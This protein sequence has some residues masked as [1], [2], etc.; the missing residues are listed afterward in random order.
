[1]H[2]DFIKKLPLPSLKNLQ[3]FVEV[4]SA[5]SINTAA[6]HLNITPSAVSHQIAALE[7]FLG[8]KLFIRNGKG[9]TLTQ[10]G[11]E[12]LHQISG[13]LN[14]IGRVSDKMINEPHS[15][16][17]RVHSAPS[18]GI[19]WLIRKLG[20]FRKRHPEILINL[21]C[22][23]ENLQFSRD[24][25]DIDIRH[26]IA[27]WDGYRVLTIKNERLQV[28]AS[29][30]Y[31]AEHPLSGPEEIINHNLIH[32]SSTLANWERWFSYHKI[33]TNRH[34]YNLSFD[35]SYMSFEAAKMGLGIILE[36]S[37]LG[38]E[39]I[40][41][42]ILKS[43]FAEQY[44]YPINAHHLVMPHINERT[45]KVRIFIDWMREELLSEGYEL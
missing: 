36:S 26:G 40:N 2:N 3:A 35:R 29:P 31:L 28:M 34:G 33:N 38:T 39:L 17:L 32:S 15:E 42:G 45:H 25:I 11:E 23:Y 16:V 4:A 24:N 5:G 20:N 27:A 22:S 30:R 41:Q 37:M 14:I 44:T 13:A 19:L 9:V 43:V 12:Y 18:F 7:D 8:R 10:P 21:T 6:T 1:M